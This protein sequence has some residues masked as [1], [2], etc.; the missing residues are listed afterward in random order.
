MKGCLLRTLRLQVAANIALSDFSK[1]CAEIGS[2]ES[3]PASTKF[4]HKRLIKGIA[5]VLLLLFM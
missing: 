2:E 1:A 3:K 4:A 5:R